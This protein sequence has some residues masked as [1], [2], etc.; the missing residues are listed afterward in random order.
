MDQPKGEMLRL[1]KVLEAFANFDKLQNDRSNSR[2][3]NRER[4]T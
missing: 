3:V 1:E 4:H 2:R